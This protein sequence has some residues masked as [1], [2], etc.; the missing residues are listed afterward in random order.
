MFIFY[1]ENYTIVSII[2]IVIE[3]ILGFN[4]IKYVKCKLN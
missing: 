2:A 1:T 4:I 3:I